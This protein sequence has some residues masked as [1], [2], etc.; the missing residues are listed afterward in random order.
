MQRSPL[1]GNMCLRT[2]TVDGERSRG[3]V[4][5][6]AP[7]RFLHPFSGGP[8]ALAAHTVGLGDLTRRELTAVRGFVLLYSVLHPHTIAIVIET[9]RPASSVTSSYMGYPTYEN[10]LCKAR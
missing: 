6:G 9:R 3:T 2:C 8:I 7:L 1:T 10:S 4:R 5:H